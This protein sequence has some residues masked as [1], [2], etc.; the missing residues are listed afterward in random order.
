MLFRQDILGL[1]IGRAVPVI[2]CL[3][4]S[5]ISIVGA[6]FRWKALAGIAMWLGFLKIE[7]IMC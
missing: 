7:K 4:A 6:P 2:P 3:I 1:I 5:E